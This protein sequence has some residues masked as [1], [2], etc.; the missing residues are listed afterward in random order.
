MM[1]YAKAANS[2]YPVKVPKHY[3]EKVLK[4]IGYVMEDMSE[5]ES[6]VTETDHKKN[7]FDETDVMSIPLSEMNQ[8]QLRA[9]ARKKG[10]DISGTQS[11]AEAKEVVKKALAEM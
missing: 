3:F 10:I 4:P 8:K 5:S 2:K 1:V 7:N 9:F 6:A 11:F